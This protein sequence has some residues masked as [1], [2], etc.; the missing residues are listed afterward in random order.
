V[1]TWRAMNS[2]LVL[3]DQVN[4]IA[5][6]RSKASDGLV[7]DADHQATNSDHNP[8]FVS[9]VGSNIVTALDLTH[10]PVHGFDSYAFAEVLRRNRDR[11]I[12]YVISNRQIFSSYVSGSRAAWAW[13]PYTG[14]DPHT[15]HV[16]T[17]VLD[18]VVSDTK[19]PWNLEG[20]END[21]TPSQQYVQ[22]VMN[23]RLDS[24]CQLRLATVVPASTATDGTKFPGF[25]EPN[26]LGIWTV[27]QTQSDEQVKAL[28]QQ[29]IAEAADDPTIPEFHPTPEEIAALADAIAA[30][31]TVPT[32]E[33]I[34]QASAAATVAEIAS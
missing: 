9:G 16:H 33:E 13:G 3:R 26:K 27:S 7:G 34:A 5:P 1:A 32:V 24:V 18:A 22:H 15:N 14:S 20:F 30:G 12:K 19:T 11:R 6:N 4:V 31:I 8:H 17:S 21:M 23:Y 28:I 25:T 29:A 10:D 2:L